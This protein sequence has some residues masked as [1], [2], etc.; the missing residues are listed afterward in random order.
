MSAPRV[1]PGAVLPAELLDE[2]RSWQG[3]HDPY[4]VA[5]AREGRRHRAPAPSPGARLYGPPDDGDPYLAQ[6]AQER[7]HAS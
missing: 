3:D 7:G 2:E 4:L 1:E 5:L 6:L